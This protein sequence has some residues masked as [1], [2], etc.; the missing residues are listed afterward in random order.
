VTSL[1]SIA[2]SEDPAAGGMDFMP[3]YLESTNVYGSFKDAYIPFPRS[4]GAAFCSAGLLVCFGRPA[5]LLRR[6]SVRSESSS[7]PRSLS[8]LGP[9][10]SAFVPVGAIPPLFTQASGAGSQVPEAQ[11]IASFYF[12][13]RVSSKI[14]ILKNRYPRIFLFKLAI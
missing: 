14:K 8:A 9:A 10:S 13:D 11:S 3:Q 12:P 1:E 2:L 5:T 4:S 6:V 7:T